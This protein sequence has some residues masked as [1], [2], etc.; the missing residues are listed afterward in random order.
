MKKVITSFVCINLSILFCMQAIGQS[1]EPAAPPPGFEHKYATVNGIKIH[2]VTGGKGE[3]LLLIHG[4][5]QNWFMWYR[6]MPALSKHFT[7]IA[8]D[9]P[10]VGESDKPQ[11]GYDK[12]TM[13]KDIHELIKKLG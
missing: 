5:G 12:K 2:Y 7:I 8:P 13:A 11:N 3:P 6:I 9:M 10:G 4:F 1:I